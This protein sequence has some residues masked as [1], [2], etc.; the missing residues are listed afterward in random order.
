MKSGCFFILLTWPYGVLL[1]Y[2]DFVFNAVPCWIIFTLKLEFHS[3]LKELNLS[4]CR[5]E[6]SVST[7]SV[8][9]LNIIAALL[10]VLRFAF[11]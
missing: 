1:I 2:F 6:L 10:P 4:T 7:E 8:S 3:K 11:V 5:V 9:G